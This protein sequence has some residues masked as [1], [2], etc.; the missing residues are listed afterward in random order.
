M[1]KFLARVAYMDEKRM[2]TISW[3]RVKVSISRAGMAGLGNEGT[4]VSQRTHTTGST[5][6]GIRKT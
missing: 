6:S 3:E 5:Q 2:E 4:N 1:E